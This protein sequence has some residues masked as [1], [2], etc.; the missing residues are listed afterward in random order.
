M[1]P[2]ALPILQVKSLVPT[3]GNSLAKL[4]RWH[5]EGERLGNVSLDRVDV[6]ADLLFSIIEIVPGTKISHRLL[7]LWLCLRLLLRHTGT[8]LVHNLHTN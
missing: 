5:T 2:R 4:E 7:D 6:I 1:E 3:L 8:N